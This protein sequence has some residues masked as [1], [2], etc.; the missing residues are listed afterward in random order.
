RRMR[1]LDAPVERR[2]GPLDSPH[3]PSIVG[4]CPGRVPTRVTELRVATRGADRA[5][6]SQQR[7]IVVPDVG[8]ERLARRVGNGPQPA[9][10]RAML[11]AGPAG[12]PR[13]DSTAEAVVGRLHA[14]AIGQLHAHE[15]I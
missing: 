7:T 9:P 14:S 2:V 1:T 8:L 11:D 15:T 12:P 13:L 5:V 10:R 4:C 3:A 6:E